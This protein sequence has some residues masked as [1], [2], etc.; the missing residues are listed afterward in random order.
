MSDNCVY[1]A[2]TLVQGHTLDL[3]CNSYSFGGDSN[4]FA[5]ESGLRTSLARLTIHQHALEHAG[6]RD[7]AACMAFIKKLAARD[8]DA[9]VT[10]LEE[11]VHL[12]N[13][14]PTYSK[15]SGK[16]L[17]DLGLNLL[18][19]AS[20]DQEVKA[21]AQTL[22]L[23]LLDIDRSSLTTN[24]LFQE[25]IRLPSSSKTGSPLYTDG[26]MMLEG[27]FLDAVLSKAGSIEPATV[28]RFSDW[29]QA[30]RK[31]LHEDNVSKI[32]SDL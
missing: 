4:Q 23:T 18:L 21:A 27:A 20:V 26:S 25:G 11:A 10:S 1:A 22:L 9:C 30:L 28:T 13:A 8:A 6:V 31:A 7:A 29:S 24:E 14:I 17:I 3:L 32:S 12:L 15:L 16:A 2:L 19:D 5:A